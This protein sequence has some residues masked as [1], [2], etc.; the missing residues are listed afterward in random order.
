MNETEILEALDRAVPRYDDRHGDWDA[1]AADLRRR[2]TMSVGALAAVA[3]AV[4]AAVLLWPASSH[5][6]GVLDRA[7]AAVGDGPV[8]HSCSA[9]RRGTT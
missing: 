8:L 4:A 1:V 6:G 5:Q 2:R 3:L 7:L 9:R